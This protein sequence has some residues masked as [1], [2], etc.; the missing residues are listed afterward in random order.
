MY[1]QDFLQSLGLIYLG[2]CLHNKIEERESREE[3]VNFIQLATTII[4]DP[5]K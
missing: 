2:Y 5:F 3:P 1:E 4:E